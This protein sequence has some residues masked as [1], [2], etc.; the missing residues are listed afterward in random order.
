MKT[1]GETKRKNEEEIKK[2]E[3]KLFLLFEVLSLFIIITV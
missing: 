1:D 2:N 3:G